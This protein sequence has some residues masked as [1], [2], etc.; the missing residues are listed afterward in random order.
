MPKLG[1]FFNDE[2]RKASVERQLLPG[3]V[4]YL[5][6]AFPQITKNK[7]LVFVGEENPDV[8]T[9]IVNSQTNPFILNKPHL[10]ICQVTLDA[11]SHPFLKHDSHIACH[12]VLRLSRADVIID[13]SA[14]LSRIKGTVSKAVREQIVSAV[15]S[16]K[17]L[18]RYTQNVI[19]QSLAIDE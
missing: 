8:L 12:Q 14:D 1:D 10:N 3:A 11:A 19:I 5:E 18:D 17:T 4:I 13:L 15:K 9:F 2:D 16:A 6:V 7:F